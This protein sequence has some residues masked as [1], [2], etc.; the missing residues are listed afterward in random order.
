MTMSGYDLPMLAPSVPVADLAPT[1][2]GL[3]SLAEHVLAPD[4]HRATGRI[5]LRVTPGGFGQ[6]EH[7]V[8]GVRRRLRIDGDRL[9]VDH[10]AGGE[11]W[12]PITTLGDAA[13]LVDLPV[14]ATTG[15]FTPSSDATPDAP[16]QVEAAALAD[17]SAW[18]RLVAAALEEFRRRHA[19]RRPTAVQLW[20]E[21]F[22]VATAMSEV[23]FGGSPGDDGRPEP[24]VYV[25]PWSPPSVGGFW[26]EPYG[27]AL[28]RSEVAT[29]DDALA[30]LERG[31]EEAD[32]R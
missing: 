2:R 15:V 1:R 18:F 8:D 29:V 25:G 4:L 12:H 14:G 16:L 22:D 13:A 10:D 3:H 24:Y 26:N 19:V 30:F 32:R 17:L 11:S 5:G 9:V 6:P 28:G 20:P 31:L 27:A 21:H 7:L 23:N